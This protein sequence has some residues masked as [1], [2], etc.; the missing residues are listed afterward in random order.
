MVIRLQGF[1]RG[2]FGGNFHTSNNLYIPPGLDAVC[3]SC[4]SDYVQGFRN[5][6]IQAR[7]G[8]VVM[9]VDCTN[10][11]NLRHLYDKDRGWETTYPSSGVLSFDAIRQYG[12]SGKAAIAIVTYGNGV[13][14]A[15]QARRVLVDDGIINSAS[16]VDVVDCP[17]LSRVPDELRK[18]I[19]QY[20]K[21]LFAD[22][23]KQGNGILASHACSLQSDGLLPAQWDI[24][25]AP[26]TY[27]PLGN[28]CTFL[29]KSDIVEA[30]IKL[31]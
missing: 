10:L 7:A 3:Y 2:I 31:L 21:V 9:S 29:N 18:P 25:T 4:G 1:D 26:R 24:V 23:C 22:I 20:D 11:L 5:A 14:T 8:R 27:N 28:T 17:Y 19:Q 6:I 13:V 16:H 30:F 12:S 15:L